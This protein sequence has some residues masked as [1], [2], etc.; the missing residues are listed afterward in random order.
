MLLYLTYCAFSV[1]AGATYIAPARADLGVVVDSE[2]VLTADALTRMT[3]FWSNF[4]KEPD[5]I[6]SARSKD[7]F[8]KDDQVSV[9]SHSSPFEHVHISAIADK[10][11]S[12]AADLKQAGLTAPQFNG[13]YMA[14]VS[15]LNTQTELAQYPADSVGPTPVE[16]QNIAFIKAHLKEVTALKSNGLYLPIYDVTFGKKPKAPNAHP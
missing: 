14:L 9:G 11:P 8:R 10:Y 13:Y 12:V 3:S 16:Q 2:P 4:K 5:S 15:A 7:P 6:Y 1:M